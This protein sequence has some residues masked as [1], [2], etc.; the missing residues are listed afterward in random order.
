MCYCCCFLFSFF[1][2]SLCLG[3]SLKPI[4][5]IIILFVQTVFCN[6]AT[7]THTQPSGTVVQLPF[8]YGSESEMC[9]ECKWNCRLAAALNVP[10]GIFIGV[11]LFCLSFFIRSRAFCFS[12]SIEGSEWSQKRFIDWLVFKRIVKGTVLQFHVR[13]DT[14]THAYVIV[15]F[16]LCQ[17][18]QF[19]FRWK[20]KSQSLEINCHMCI[21][22]R[23]QAMLL[24]LF[25]FH[26][27]AWIC[28][29]ATEDTGQEY[30][31]LHFDDGVLKCMDSALLCNR[32]SHP[33]DWKTPLSRIDLFIR[34][35]CTSYTHDDA[36]AD[37]VQRD[38]ICVL[39]CLS[40]TAVSHFFSFVFICFTFKF[41]TQ[42]QNIH[43]LH[44]WPLCW[45]DAV[46][47]HQFH[48]IPLAQYGKLLYLFGLCLQFQ[49]PK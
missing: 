25:E 6:D 40:N 8:G 20:K 27:F 36:V 24:L 45:H 48:S 13:T 15:I 33:T 35:L 26:K 9:N 10:R 22:S 30:I 42:Q 2:H 23:Y 7:H 28:L 3:F 1:L 44:L 39:V 18:I 43:L 21:S 29:T 32:N 16:F 37:L 4:I 12:Y 49:K 5:N 14:L 19:R 17:S 46:W 47:T 38:S 31:F 34:S 41:S 11:S